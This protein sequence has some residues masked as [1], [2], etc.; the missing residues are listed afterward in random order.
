ML[1]ISLPVGDDLL[2]I[3]HSFWKGKDVIY[4]N[5]ELMSSKKRFFT[6]KHVFRV[7]NALTG[8]DDVFRI[9]VGVG[10]NGTSYGVKRNDKVLLGTWRD[11]L[12]HLNREKMPEEAMPG[13]DLNHPPTRRAAP[14]PEP[15]GGWREEDL[16]V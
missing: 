7:P 1:R 4:W 12:T 15:V 3:H 11:H 9:R 5:G 10:L 2:E 6:S 14:L 16:I 13:L 8:E